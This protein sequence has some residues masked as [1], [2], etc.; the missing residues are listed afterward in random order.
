MKKSENIDGIYMVEPFLVGFK[1]HY[2]NYVKSLYNI[3]TQKKNIF[4]NIYS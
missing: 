3:V 2:Y 1:G 4:Q